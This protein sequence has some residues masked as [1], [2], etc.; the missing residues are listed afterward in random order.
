MLNET[1][2][3]IYLSIVIFFSLVPIVFICMCLIRVCVFEL[4][5]RSEERREDHREN[6]QK[7]IMGASMLA[8]A[9]Q[10][11]QA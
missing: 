5:E 2:V 7:F 1:W 10:P 11:M 8:R 9:P 3:P 4:E 6:M